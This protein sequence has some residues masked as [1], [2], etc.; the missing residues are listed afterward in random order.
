VRRCLTFALAVAAAGVGTSCS[1]LYQP[2]IGGPPAP[3]SPLAIATSA[4][5]PQVDETLLGEMQVIGP[6]LTLL[7][8][9][10]NTAGPN[11]L[12]IWPVSFSAKGG[13]GQGVILTGP[14]ETAGNAMDSERLELHGEYV[15]VA[16]RD[17]SIPVG[18]EH[19]PMFLV[20]R[21]R[22]VAT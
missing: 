9:E 14:M 12:P 22:N 7:I 21:V 17:A 5:D 6:C 16:P 2:I 20:G 11:V 13:E 18:C 19:Y 10:G 1:L 3:S 4:V 15:D 8:R